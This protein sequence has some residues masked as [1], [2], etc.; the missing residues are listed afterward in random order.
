MT[1]LNTLR[2]RIEQLWGR[3]E[4][5]RDWRN[6]SDA[7]TLSLNEAA[8]KPWA[9]Y[10]GS[11]PQSGGKLFASLSYDDAET[12]ARIFS[13]KPHAKVYAR[14]DTPYGELL[15]GFFKKLFPEAE[16]GRATAQGMG[17]IHAVLAEGLA[18]GDHV[19]ASTYQFGT[20]RKV[21]EDML[22]RYKIDVTFVDG[23]KPEA[24][25]AAVRPNTKMF[26]FEPIGNPGAEIVDIRKVVSVARQPARDIL[27]VAD[28]CMSPL[29]P[30]LKLGAD[31]AALSTT[32]ILGGGIDT[33]GMLLVTKDGLD[34]L[35]RFNIARGMDPEPMLLRRT[36]WDGLVQSHRS[37]AAMLARAPSWLSGF[38]RQAGNAAAVATAAEE[39]FQDRG[40][41]VLSPVLESHPQ[42][43]L[44][45]EQ[46][47]GSVITSFVLPSMASAF[48]FINQLAKNGMGIVNNFGGPAT[49]V[50][51]PASTTHSSLTPE[52]LTEQGIGPGLV[53]VSFGFERREF[54]LDVFTR[55]FDEALPAA[56]P[57]THR[58]RAEIPSHHMV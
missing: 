6:A 37:S 52:K 30:V 54:L 29:D 10:D 19:V 26:F 18:T 58:S 41:T 22:P 53:R 21:L 2:A 5:L 27:V 8:Q 4:V 45:R 32:K 43:D 50:T 31:V 11:K 56:K 28:S 16:Q 35:S 1:S 39:R 44:A 34:R 12:A 3:Y 38:R 51:H 23:R 13:Q 49:T 36:A 33:G 42:H 57:P 25:D 14:E 7:L 47:G 15:V 55:A 24:W 46:F 9:I 17:A 48:T 40:L 20:T